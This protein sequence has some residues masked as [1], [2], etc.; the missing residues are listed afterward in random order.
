[1]ALRPVFLV[2]VTCSLIVY[3]YHYYI[4]NHLQGG[5]RHASRAP[6]ASVWCY[7]GNVGDVRF[8]MRISNPFRR[9]VVLLCRD[10]GV[11]YKVVVAGHEYIG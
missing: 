4:Y 1:M 3:K 10:V 2:P 8:E 5:L 6:F 11:T 9:R 7:V